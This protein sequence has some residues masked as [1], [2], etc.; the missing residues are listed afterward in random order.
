M[1]RPVAAVVVHGASVRSIA[2]VVVVL[3]VRGAGLRD[4]AGSVAAVA[5]VASRGSHSLLV[6][7]I[8][9]AV[10]VVV[11]VLVRKTRHCHSQQPWDE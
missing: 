8:V 1:A 7:D 2:L 5:A 3:V 10:A 11:A 4:A 9:V 6:V